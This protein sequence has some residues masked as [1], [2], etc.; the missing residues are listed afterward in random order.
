ME[1]DAEGLLGAYTDPRLK[2]ARACPFCKGRNL[3]IFPGPKDAMFRRKTARVT[4]ATCYAQGPVAASE[5]HAVVMWNGDL[6]KSVRASGNVNPLKPDKDF[7][8]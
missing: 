6:T 4:C 7:Q 2:D 5:A 1:R 3:A 8:H